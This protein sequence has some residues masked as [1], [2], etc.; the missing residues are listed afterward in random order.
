[1]NP[2]DDP[3][4]SADNPGATSSV[5]GKRISQFGLLELLLLMAAVCVWLPWWLNRQP[6]SQLPQQI[7]ELR[8]ALG[9]LFVPDA[10]QI[11]A[12]RM[13]DYRMD[14]KTWQLYL[15]P[16]HNYRLH[17]ADA[18][19]TETSF[20]SAASVPIEPGEHQVE[21]RRERTG[22]GPLSTQLFVDGISVLER[23]S[24]LPPSTSTS[25]SVSG[26]SRDQSMQAP[27]G[28]MTIQ[29]LRN[30]L[31]PSGNRTPEKGTDGGL[32][33]LETV[34]QPDVAKE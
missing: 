12:R 22:S 7:D 20:P 34:G 6:L 4:T 29:R 30:Y 17:V 27:G 13:A 15:P 16:G 21:W 33:W 19:I 9:E 10:T 23:E 1:M 5:A 28:P 25:S 26:V 31:T 24:S 3:A 14:T 8:S 2:T 32:L 11:V 18:E